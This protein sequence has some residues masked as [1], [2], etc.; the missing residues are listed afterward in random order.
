MKNTG[1]NRSGLAAGNQEDKRETILC[2]IAF[3][4]GTWV[5]DVPGEGKATIAD[6]KGIRAVVAMLR[7]EGVLMEPDDIE[8]A[9]S[10]GPFVVL[11]G[12][13]READVVPVNDDETAGLQ[14]EDVDPG[15]DGE[16][17]SE[18]GFAL[19]G[20]FRSTSDPELL[21]FYGV[22]QTHHTGQAGSYQVIHDCD[23]RV[24]LLNAGIAA[25]TVKGHKKVA[26]ALAEEKEVLRKKRNWYINSITGKLRPFYSKEAEKK[27][28]RCRMMIV[29]GLQSLGRTL[30]ATWSNLSPAINRGIDFIYKERPYHKW[31]VKLPPKGQLPGLGKTRQED[32]SGA[33][34]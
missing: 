29:R 21:M 33:A 10:K 22:R 32:G 28:L 24:A 11:G 9:A 23:R 13:R 6:T 7:N 12:R 5:F 2:R 8:E 27:A 17:E 25:A 16:R 1:K 30:P 4:G 15:E 26:K 34:A 18:T 14:E 19:E 20:S 3:L 31:I